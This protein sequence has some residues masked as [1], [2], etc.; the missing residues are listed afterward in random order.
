MDQEKGENDNLGETLL[1][2]D[3]FKVWATRQGHVLISGEE[4]A[5]LAEIRKTKEYSE[6][7]VKVIE[8]LKRSPTKCLR[9]EEWSEEQGLILFWGKVYVPNSTEL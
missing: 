1:K 2:P 9:E 8:E 7:V 4:E 5:T 3:F 6:S